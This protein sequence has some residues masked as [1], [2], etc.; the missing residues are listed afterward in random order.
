[1]PNILVVGS[2]NADLVVRAPRFP[3]PGETISG[4]DLQIIPG[5]KG[6]NQAVAAAR[7]GAAVSMVGRVGVD[8]FG[9]ELINN[10]KRNNVDT[11]GVQIDA[12]SST[13][14]AIIVVDSNGQNS[15]VLSP[16]GNGRVSEAD[17][18]RLSFPEYNLL[19][20][21]L[22]VPIGTVLSAAW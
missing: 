19:L 21:Q 6:A 12:G 8:S 3:Q 9:P 22:E 7:Q 2:L 1:M 11:S 15:I 20:L 18:E 13:G 14:T 4:N 5:G 17:L 10:L 16:G